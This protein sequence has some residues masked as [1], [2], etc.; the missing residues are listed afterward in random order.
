ML[1]GG[2]LTCE[3]LTCAIEFPI[4]RTRAWPA[5]PVTTTA[6]SW[7]RLGASCTVTVLTLSPLTVSRSVTTL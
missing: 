6:S 7:S 2:S 4:S 5:V 3:R 1:A